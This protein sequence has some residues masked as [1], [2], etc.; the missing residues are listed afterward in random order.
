MSDWYHGDFWPDISLYLLVKLVICCT[1]TSF[2]DW[3]ECLAQSEFCFLA[4]NWLLL[5]I[6]SISIIIHCPTSLL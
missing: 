4:G 6:I 2:L 5:L 3:T 1:C